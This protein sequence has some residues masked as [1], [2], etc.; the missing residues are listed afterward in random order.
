MKKILVSVLALAILLAM[1]GA[2]AFSWTGA[3]VHEC[4]SYTI[5]LIKYR[6]QSLDIGAGFI[7]DDAATASKGN[8]VYFALAVYDSE[9]QLVDDDE[10]TITVNDL[11]NVVRS[12]DLYRAQVVGDSPWLKVSIK[13][14]TSINEL[15]FN[16]MPV[17][18][19]DT[20]VSIGT[21]TFTRN[22]AGVVQDVTCTENTALMLE[23]LAELGISI[24]QIY[25][26]SICMSN[27]VLIS[28]FG[29]ICLSE[30][31]ISWAKPVA[32]DIIHPD[33]LI[34]IPKTGDSPM[35]NVVMAS[36]ALAL[37]LIWVMNHRR[38]R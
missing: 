33:D 19:A 32:S 6:R 12:N 15:F 2:F 36:L 37:I 17:N 10:Y 23:R 8:H 9:G 11:T 30:K 7:Q 28:N 16:G 18:V 29:R 1:G 13:E 24:D 21:L 27:D 20:K 31:S 38:F 22:A 25:D 35:L 3:T 34:L 4:E 5:S 26:G 14:Q